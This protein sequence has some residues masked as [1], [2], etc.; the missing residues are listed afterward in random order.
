MEQQTEM[1]SQQLPLPNMKYGLTT[2]LS[3]EEFSQVL[4]AKSPV[5]YTPYVTTASPTIKVQELKEFWRS[6]R[7]KAIYLILKKQPTTQIEDIQQKAL[8]QGNAIIIPAD[9]VLTQPIM[10]EKQATTTIDA[11]TMIIIV[12]KNSKASIIETSAS[13]QDCYLRTQRLH[14]ILEENAELSF[15][16]I[17]NLNKK[18]YNFMSKTANTSRNAKI[19]W[20][21]GCFGS[22]FTSSTISTTLTGEA[23]SMTADTMFFAQRDQQFDL[24]VETQ[25]VASH[26]TSDMRTKGVGKDTSKTV[27]RGNIKIHENA[28]NSVGYQKEDTLI[29]SD[30]ATVD[31]IPKLEIDNQDVKCKHGAT[32][33]QIDKDKLFYLTSRGLSDGE[34]Q[35]AIVRGFFA[36]TIE[37]INAEEIKKQLANEI[38]E[39]TE[40]LIEQ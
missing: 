33:G 24:A 18:T 1:I 40:F 21:D 4:L 8:D 19:A 38:E 5:I 11:D 6:P 34:A 14:I 32:V 35:A 27:Y 23:S 7:G 20:I 13:T 16:N 26:T 15:C 9:Q 12:E 39:K 10:L 30:D 28:H 37:K 25:H 36:P 31:A 3:L 2:Y 17:Q 29:L 22:L